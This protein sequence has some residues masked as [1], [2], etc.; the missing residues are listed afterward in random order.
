MCR[1]QHL[2][3]Y[4][5]VKRRQQG[6]ALLEL[7]VALAIGLLLSVLAAGK[8]AREAD[9]LALRA[10]GQWMAQL[11]LALE[12]ALL[13]RQSGSASPFGDPA[14]PT[15]AELVRAGFLPPGFPLRS[16]A[17][18]G[19]SLRV[20][21]TA[22]CTDGACRVDGLVIADQALQTPSG[23][24]DLMRLS[25]LLQPLGAEG[26]YADASLSGAQF[27]YPN[28]PV[29]GMAALKPGTPF[30]WA[31]THGGLDPRYV[32][33]GDD[34]DPQLKAGLSVG[35]AIQAAGSLLAGGV[36]RAEARRQQ[37]GF[38]QPGEKGALA[39]D[40]NGKLLHCQQSRW[41][42]VEGRFGGAYAHNNIYGCRMHNGKSTK[43]PLT[44][45]CSCAKGYAPTLVAY[46]GKWLETEGW[47]YGY[48]CISEDS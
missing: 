2:C 20:L 32:R 43:N 14:A 42:P 31:G 23:E 22:G 8:W 16:P 5:A 1:S 24:P 18:F 27:R 21:P 4:A 48:V 28:P 36:V 41:R 12:Q 9:D 10:S 30:A 19:V 34:R 44:G 39:Q 3:V 26:G 13:K 11:R 47:T 45:E 35:G 25:P 17:G 29:P 46:G 40:A 38:C 37:G 6:Y 33:V 15:L 7:M